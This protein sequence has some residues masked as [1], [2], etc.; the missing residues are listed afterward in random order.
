MSNCTFCKI[1]DGQ[2]PSYQVLEDEHAL[3]F[4]DIR[5]ASPGH[6]LVV[7]RV[8]A[9]DVWEISMVAHSEVADMVHRVATDLKL[10]RSAGQAAACPDQ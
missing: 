2:L 7:P 10:M 8:H 1:V 4:L 6:T 5:P 9:R 3:A